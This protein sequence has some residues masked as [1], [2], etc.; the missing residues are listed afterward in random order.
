MTGNA[1]ANFFY[2]SGGGD[3]VRAGGGDDFVEIANNAADVAGGGTGNDTLYL[4]D[5]ESGTLVGGKFSLAL[6]GTVQSTGPGTVNASGFENV[7]GGVLNDTLT[8][9]IHANAIYGGDRNDVLHGGGGDDTLYGDARFGLLSTDG[10]HTASGFAIIKDASL[11]VDHLSGG[12]GKDTLI[13]G[14][15]G[16]Y[17][18]G[19]AGADTFVLQSATD[20]YTFFESR[21][22]IR[23][24]HHSQGDKIDLHLISAAFHLH[25]SSFTHVADELIQSRHGSKTIVQG[26]VNGDGKP[27]FAIALA[28][29]PVLV[30]DD[31]VL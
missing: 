29:H 7:G 14:A 19:G 27:D 12:T 26:D 18:T 13:G 28:H 31:F 30:Q 9:D 22:L 21:D 23:D 24:F 4:V 25:G 1:D 5:F 11:G 15:G 6:Q 10:N 16:D 3:Q 17:L 2:T 20:S 8:G